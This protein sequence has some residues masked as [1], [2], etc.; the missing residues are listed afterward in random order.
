MSE[1]ERRSM[2]LRRIR[3]MIPVVR[4]LLREIR[5]DKMGDE[6]EVDLMLAKL[7]QLQALLDMGTRDQLK[8][9]KV[10]ERLKRAFRK[11]R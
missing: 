3:E 5:A 8:F 7:D 10:L 9:V 11:A 1:I 6:A 2:I 4:G